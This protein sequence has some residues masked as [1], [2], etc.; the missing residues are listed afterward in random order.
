L[1]TVR[2][3]V[4]DKAAVEDLFTCPVSNRKWLLV[5]ALAALRAWPA[6][7]V[8][9]FATDPSARGW[10]AFGDTN[11]FHWDS[12][13]Q[14]LEVT[15]DSSRPNSYF[16]RSLGTILAKT[17]DAQLSF[18][19]QLDDIA[20]G[21]NPTRPFTFELGVGL[22]NLT[23]ATSTNFVRGTATAS[24]N[25]LE[26]DYFPDSG[27][28]ATV[29][30]VIVS[31]NSQFIPAFSFPLELTVHDL[32][33][34]AMLYSATNQTLSTTMTRNGAPFGPVKQVKLPDTFTDYRLDTVAVSSYSDAGADGSL[35]AEGRID[36]ISV[37]VPDPPTTTLTLQSLNPPTVSFQTRTNWSYTL[38]RTADWHK[39]LPVSPTIPGTGEQ[40][41]LSDT[42][43][44]ATPLSGFYRVQLERP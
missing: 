16:Y 3:R 37:Q 44:A 2:G 38:D 5:L 21:V 31:S 28:G 39:W 20:V 13:R 36:N 8:E 7:W 11:L 33:H 25:L 17:D 23:N 29:S 6:Q 34:V 18:D 9:D 24:P 43:S 1:K 26:F 42:Q 10:R 35:L 27:F 15:W 30:P 19:L 4:C 32:F 12:S 40:Q 22:V 14:D 41:T